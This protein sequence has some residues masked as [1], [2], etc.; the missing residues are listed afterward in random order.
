MEDVVVRACRGADCQ[1]LASLATQLG[2]PCTEDE[3]RQRLPRHQGREACV[4]LVAELGGR[5]V[6]WE[7]LEVVDRFYLDRY[8]EVTGLVV[9]EAWRGRG[10]GGKLVSAAESWAR[11][12]GLELLRL[13][14]NSQRRDAHR[15]YQGLGFEKTKEQFVYV[16]RIV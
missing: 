8:A 6:A 16:K 13:K 3:V 1:S 7:S 9:D 2:Y 15:F 11:S 14:T 4:I 5:V 10:I 12:V